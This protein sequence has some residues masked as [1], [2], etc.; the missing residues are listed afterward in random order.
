MS[1]QCLNEL[2]E[3]QVKDICCI[4]DS[5]NKHEGTKNQ[6][7]LSNEF[8]VYP[9]MMS[10]FLYYSEEELLGILAI[11]ASTTKNAVI[12]AYVLPKVRQQGIFSE[13]FNTASK[14][15]KHFGYKQVIFKTE[16]IFKP[17]AIIMEK[18]KAEKVDTELLMNYNKLLQ[19]PVKQW[20]DGLVVRQ[21]K[22][23][24]RMRLEQIDAEAFQNSNELAE[25]N[26]KQSFSNP[27]VYFFVI[28][29]HDD[30]LGS[31]CVD[32]EGKCNLLYSLCIDS[33]YQKKGIG[34]FL[35]H[36]T[37][38]QISQINDKTI[39]LVV[40][41]KNNHALNMYRSCG[42]EVM[43]EFHFYEVYLSKGSETC[44]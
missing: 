9:E 36:E 19:V 38:H 3:K 39:S 17:A 18:Y 23:D 33:A 8:N 43:T 21:A 24:D 37:V 7:F 5:C 32:V 25:L 14:E 13:L 11:S 35:L 44:Y 20:L 29:N 4:V 40:D 42:F 34:T 10:F 6:L 41:L 26:I 15:L 16:K 28:L 30:V 2:S 22:E 31:C 27:S 12:S 1:I